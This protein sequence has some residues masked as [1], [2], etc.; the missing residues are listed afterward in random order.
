MESDDGDDMEM[1]QKE[2]QKW[3]REKVA[4][5]KLVDPAA[6]KRCHLQSLLEKREKQVAAL[7]TLCESVAECEAVM[8]QLYSLLEWEYRDTDSD[9]D[10]MGSQN[11]VIVIDDNDGPDANSHNDT[12]D[13]DDA[14]DCD[15]MSPFP[16]GAIP[17]KTDAHSSLTTDSQIPKSQHPQTSKTVDK[18]KGKRPPGEESSISLVLRKRPVVVLTKLPVHKF[19]DNLRQPTPHQSSSEEDEL[20]SCDS[21]NRWEPKGESSDSDYSDSKTK[22]KKKR[23]TR[24]K[25]GKRCKNDAAKTKSSTPLEKT[26][27]CKNT[28]TNTAQRNANVSTGTKQTRPNKVTEPT[29]GPVV[30]FVSQA[31]P[32]DATQ[33]PSSLPDEEININMRVLARRRSMRW[34]W[35]E[36][37]AI[38]TKEGYGLK[39]KVHFEENGR[40]LVSGHHIAFDHT[41][42]LERLYV[43]ARVVAKY[44]K[45]D[46][47]CFY[48]GIL[49]ELPSRK[50]RMRFLV[51]FDN[52]T[53]S[54]IGLPSLHLVCRPL[55][56]VWEDIMCSPHKEFI[57]DYLN[58]WPYPAMAQ[59]KQEQKLNV[60]FEGVLKKCEVEQIDCSLIHIVFQD[61]Q[62]KEWVYRGSMRL[63]HMIIMKKHMEETKD[64]EES[65]NKET[66]KPKAG[67]AEQTEDTSESQSGSTS[68]PKPE[69]RTS[70]KTTKRAVI[71]K[72]ADDQEVSVPSPAVATYTLHQCCP[73]CLDHIRPKSNATENRGRNPLFVPLLY[74]FRRIKKAPKR[75]GVK[76]KS[77]SQVYYRCPCGLSLCSMATIQDYLIQTRC[78]F[79]H[80]E[81]FCLDP[82]VSVTRTYK[83]LPSKIYI[84][85]LAQGRESQLVS[86]I[87]EHNSIRPSAILYS[88]DRL[89]SGD[90]SINTSPDFMVGCDCTDG[91]RDSMACS[92]HQLTFNVASPSPGGPGNTG[93]GYVHNRLNNRI[94]TGVY[95]CNALC[96]C[97]PRTCSNR[98]VQRGVQLR[99]QVFMTQGRGWGIRCL[100]DVAKGTFVCTFSGRVRYGVNNINSNVYYAKLNHIE[101]VEIHKEDYEAEAYCSDSETDPAEGAASKGKKTTDSSARK[102]RPKEL[103]VTTA[104]TRGFFDGE[105][106][107]YV[108]DAETDGNLARYFNHSCSPN[109]FE[110]N[111]FVDTHDLRFPLLAFFTRKRIKAGTELT[112]DYKS[113]TGGVK[114]VSRGLRCQCGSKNCRGKL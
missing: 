76:S 95:E 4:K 66:T 110:Q 10:T 15:Y 1:T 34:E 50:N 47:F 37:V 98:V 19:P 61:D 71:S 16:N 35:G 33:P 62:H 18:E 28:T 64:A 79:L 108:I 44:V 86:C 49:A 113:V 32:S 14:M 48:S 88:R 72:G 70:P 39:Y 74:E 81:M 3:I 31:S 101:D 112:W 38:V 107:C 105:E 52:H 45:D 75:V 8:K 114:G 90:I 22:S 43:G 82:H 20:S 42:S 59:Y 25:T 57:K 91:C 85:D 102:K 96:H 97:D 111:V 41:P 77:S 54:Y 92:C 109:L 104:T 6:L 2:L 106:C 27:T 23:E 87:N 12:D 36:I 58:V 7:H 78:D 73:A 24:S 63:E 65:K 26:V 29:C 103:V 53:P 56:D 21:D 13:G 94:I 89:V 55:K 83:S 11:P 5:S 60:E 9:D 100:D 51:F 69:K 40:G 17:S 30:S 93:A 80:L 99:L 67:S 46:K 84:P 68:T